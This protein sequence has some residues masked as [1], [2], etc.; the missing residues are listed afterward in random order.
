MSEFQLKGLG[1]DTISADVSG[2]DDYPVH[3]SLLNKDTIIIENLTNLLSLTKFSFNFSC[4]P[5]KFE[6]AD[7]SPVRAVA[8]I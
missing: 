2:T 3:K 6:G 8:Y 4:F 7:G 5:I 1:L